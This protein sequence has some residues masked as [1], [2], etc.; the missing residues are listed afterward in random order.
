MS[1]VLP[2]L[3]L[4]LGA[5]FGLAVWIAFTHRR[6]TTASERAV[7][8]Q[9]ARAVR[10]AAGSRFAAEAVDLEP[11]IREVAAA[12]ASVARAHLVRIDLAVSDAMT[13]HMDPTVLGMALRE[14]MLTAIQAAA[15]GQVLVT[16]LTLG[17]QLH[18]RVTDDGLGADQQDREVSTRGAEA[19]I[20][21]QGGSLAVEAR[22][23]RG[24][25]VTVR[26]PLPGKAGGEEMSSL[27][28][29]PVLAN[30]AA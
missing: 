12:L 8:D 14:T 22:P 1:I 17:S 11:A 19:L 30:Q 15:G 2:G 29:F 5:P 21:L 26:L 6:R 28:Q 20:A 16:T 9:T 13:V 23:G 25:T 24:T 3:L 10:P 18:I 27:T 4:T 7:A